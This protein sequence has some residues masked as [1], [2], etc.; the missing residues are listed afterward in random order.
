MEFCQK[1]GGILLIDGDKNPA[2]AKCGHR[3]KGK[4]KL[5]SFEKMN[6]SERIAVVDESK[7]T[8]YPI[9]EMKCP[10]CKNKE[11]FFW[12]MQT[13]ASD[14][15]ETKFYKCVKCEHTWRVYK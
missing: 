13:R 7:M 12:T 11:A 3:H 8:T 5:Q 10:E 6:V 1:C 4:L 15:S 14:E 9:V 2:C